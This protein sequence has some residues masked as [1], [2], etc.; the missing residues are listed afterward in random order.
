[1]QKIC[2]IYARNMQEMCNIYVRNVQ[3]MKI[4][5]GVNKRA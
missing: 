2:N 4:F 1:M 5:C 3:K